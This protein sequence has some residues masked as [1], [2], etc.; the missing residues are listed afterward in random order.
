MINSWTEK[1]RRS[2]AWIMLLVFYAEMAGSAY[3]AKK[4]YVYQARPYFNS[5][6]TLFPAT[7]NEE[8]KAP[9]IIAEKV[10]AD[11]ISTPLKV[12]EVTSEG[13]AV[14]VLATEAKLMADKNAA[15]NN[16]SSGGPGQPESSTFKSVGADNMV[17]LFTGDFSYNI[18]L[19]DVD[20]YPINI[21]Y[22][23]GVTMDQESSWVG[24]GWNI[25]SGS[26]N[27]N[28]RGVPDDFDGSNVV[29][30]EQSIEPEIT[31]GVN[32][33]VDLEIVGTPNKPKPVQTLLP[34]N[35]GFSGGVSYNNKRGLGIEAG[36]NAVFDAQTIVAGKVKDE[37]T[38]K[39][40]IG[41]N[42][43]SQT[44]L[45][46]SLGYQ[47]YL[48]KDNNKT[49]FGLST[50]ADFNA[51]TGLTDLRLS[52]EMKQQNDKSCEYFLPHAL[53]V[54]ST[55]INFARSSY[56]PTIRMPLTNF[57]ASYRAQFGKEIFSKTKTFSIGGAYNRSAIAAN[58][59]T[60]KKP[61]FGYMYYEKANGNRDALMDFNRLN[62]GTYNMK[63]PAISVPVYTY[64]VF[65][66]SGEGTGGS[67]RGYRGN[68]GYVRD[69]YTRTN[70][71]K[72]NL[73][74]EFS[75]Q[76]KVKVGVTVG[77][78]YSGTVVDDWRSQNALRQVAQFKSSEK[79]VQSGFYF[80]NPGEKAIIDQDYYHR[81]G[82]DQLM[83]PVMANVN[84]LT[85]P[86]NSPTLTLQSKFQLYN[87]KREE[88]E[89]IPIDN[90]IRKERDKRGQV[91]SF[92][93][94][95]EADRVGLDRYI[96]SYPELKESTLF[97]PGL[98]AD[99]RTSKIPIRRLNNPVEP[100]RKSNHISEITVQ[101][102]SQR[103]I[104]G[105]PV[106]ETKR[107]EVTF[108]IE[109]DLNPV[110]DHGTVAYNSGVD[111]S[112]DN[113]KGR[114]HLFQAETT[115][116][117][118]HSFLLT[119]ILS[120]DYVD[121]TGN[122]ISDDDKG[123][124]IKFNYSRTNMKRGAF[125]NSFPLFKWRMPADLNR[126][127]YNRGLVT[128]NKDDKASYTYGEK[129][130][131]YQHSI[132]SKNMIAVFRVSGKADGL[133]I[134]GENGFFTENR[135]NPPQQKLDRIDL[136]S[137]AD[138][139]K[140]L[141][142]GTQA[143][144]IK[145]VHFTYSYELCKNFQYRLANQGK[146]TLKSIYFT[147]R[148]N[149]HQK[150]KYIFKY[151]R[152]DDQNVTYNPTNIDRWGVYKPNTDNI[153]NISNEDLP[154]SVQNKTKADLNASTWNLSQIL[155]P[156]GAK[157]DVNY[158][159]D[160]YAY[161]QDK[162]AAQMTRIAG[163][164][165]NRYSTPNNELY[166]NSIHVPDNYSQ[167]KEYVFFDL[168]LPI[169]TDEEVREKYLKDVKQLLLKLWVKVPGDQN[170]GGYEPMFVYCNI[171]ESGLATTKATP[172]S[173][174]EINHNR[175]Y[176][177]IDRVPQS[178][179]NGP[180][181]IM[182][183][184]YQ[185]LRDQLPSKAYPGYDVQGFPVLQLVR[186]LYA[187]VNNIRTGLMGFEYTSRQAGW[188]RKTD[189]TKSGARLANPELKKMGGGHR[190]K[191]V[192]ITDNWMK[193]TKVDET[194][195][196]ITDSWYGQEYDYTTTE[197][198]NGSV[199][200]ISS[201]V[202]SYEPAVGNEENPFREILQYQMKN[203]MGP[204]VAG[205]VELPLAETFFPSPIVGYSK[206]V[207]KS[208]HNKT[209]KVIRSNIGRQETEFYTTRDFPV[210]SDFTAF[211]PASRHHTTPGLIDQIFN[212]AR[213]DNLLLAQGFRV[214]LNDMNGKIKSQASYPDT[215]PLT[216][217][218]KTTYYYRTKQ[219]GDNKFKLD[220][221]IPVINDADGKIYNKLVGKDIE[222]M[223]DFR[224]HF[225]FTHSSQ[226]PINADVFT[227]AGWPVILP[228]VF[229]A[230]FQDESLFRSATTMK[231]V[232]EYGIL[233]SIENVDKGSVTGTRNL[234]YDAETGEALI[235]RTTKEF[236]NLIY[237]FNYPA[238]WAY[239]GMGAAYKNIDATVEHILMRNGKI[240][241]GLTETEIK[242]IFES[243][244]EIY[245]NEASLVGPKDNAGC[246]NIGSGNACTP[247]PLS[248]E[249]R[250]W[251]LDVSKD[252]NNATKEFIFIDRNG[253]PYNT[254]D[255]TLRIIRSG[256]RNMADISAG[257]ITS[258]VNPIIFNGDDYDRVLINNN[259]QVI[260]TG[261]VE[262]KEKWKTQ[263]ALYFVKTVNVTE[264]RL[265]RIKTVSIP[266]L[267]PAGD[268]DE[269]SYEVSSYK[270]SCNCGYDEQYYSNPDYFLGYRQSFGTGK[271]RSRK[272]NRSWINLNL[273]S[274]PTSANISK[275][276]LNFPGHS[277]GSTMP[278][279]FYYYG[280]SYPLTSHG[281]TDPHYRSGGD[282][283][284][285]VL[286]RMLARWPHNDGQWRDQFYYS[287]PSNADR[288]VMP[289]PLN[290]WQPS[291]NNAVNNIDITNMARLMLRDYHDPA[292]RFATAIRLNL[293]A[294]NSNG[295]L[296]VRTCF[297]IGSLGNLDV[298]YTD[299]NDP[300]PIG[301]VPQPGDQLAPCVITTTTKLCYSVFT[302]DFMN[303]YVQG[304]LGNWR[305]M[306]SYA[307]NG[308]RE[309][310]SATEP[311]TNIATAGVIK[312]YENFWQFDNSTNTN[313]VLTKTVPL[314]K[315]WVWTSEST[316]FNRKG[317]E[318]E[319]VDP[320]LRYNAA[321]FGYNEAL[322]VAT[323]NNS[324][325]R[326]A[327]F[328]GFEDYFFKDQ[329]C[330]LD[331]QPNK[332]HFDTKINTLLLDESQAHTG[333]YSLR[334]AAQA[335]TS[336]KMKISADNAG[337]E[338]GLN[339]HLTKT[340]VN[341]PWVVPKGIGLTGI[342]HF[343]G[344]YLG[345]RIDEQINISY[346]RGSTNVP[347][348]M[349]Y[350]GGFDVSWSGKIQ[351]A[352]SGVYQFKSTATNDFMQ[353]V[354][355]KPGVFNTVC[356]EACNDHYT[357]IASV[358]HPHLAPVTLVAGELYDISLHFVDERRRDRG[359]DGAANLSWVSLCTGRPTLVPK[360][361]L[362]PNAAAANGSV[363]A[364]TS[365]CV[366]VDQIKA[367]G[368]FLT[369]EFNLIPEQKMISSVWVK[370]GGKDEDCRCPL[371]TGFSIKL[372]TASNSNVA[373]YQAKGNI[374][375][376]WQLFE[377]EFTVPSDAAELELY[378]DNSASSN[379]TLS[380]DD[381][382][383]HPFSA[384]MKSFVYNP[385][386]LKP[387]AELDE[388][389]YASFYEY[390]DDGTLIRVKKETVQGI[391]TIQESRSG[392]QKSVT[393]L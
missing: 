88:T 115:D 62:D 218:N 148:N 244:D 84:S 94:A 81:M 308:M 166:D 251:A 53:G 367:Q 41:A 250:I 360:E 213:I 276:V 97:T 237:S 311:T 50:S 386:N 252:I 171:V 262:F 58:R 130:L 286:E 287:S 366:K 345:T 190:V 96:Y 17:N 132:E 230:I 146:L 379:T 86:F 195:T 331:C 10:E 70:S 76:E 61:A 89:L 4:Q 303:P 131:W 270:G 337:T 242:E 225:T 266:M 3:A 309:Q 177:K 319:T 274:L 123:T 255:A 355:S 87:D 377:A 165:S 113:K 290:S 301:Y 256:R 35:I 152:Q 385:Y 372:K 249:Y 295:T 351:V 200:T 348:G 7:G 109:T 340:P 138:V 258:L 180:T 281:A 329:S 57:S 170:G 346:T 231:V 156:S 92:L 63:T 122:G 174:E 293:L 211:T 339:I 137:K 39:V 135:Y 95:E 72:A 323:V 20:G 292:K 162:R 179:N 235:T 375:E 183:T 178:G 144:P 214:I 75:K 391:K 234:V 18:P 107:R 357:C 12:K 133:T 224:D 155:L 356:Y 316:Q 37:K 51:R 201:G 215:D 289:S 33:G 26:I 277:Y 384:N 304:I 15:L 23:A 217:I 102:G 100:Y 175:F 80:K 99:N 221:V 126:A 16:L 389:N 151:A 8:A 32:G 261:A 254:A 118:A 159:S 313:K 139:V 187:M 305:P 268:D 285:Y 310:Q 112:F 172:T 359:N 2:I 193:M 324:R 296:E 241:G 147:Y 134:E 236:N 19:L 300:L 352:E 229:R 320:L 282:N 315:S 143:K 222:V 43:N 342:Y 21:F 326:L 335:A 157:I 307:F 45:S 272:T 288:I 278:H 24:L 188:C 120:P 370:R 373:T 98:C 46:G 141:E 158:E 169:A 275:V 111:N 232:N 168:P 265:T 79:L 302:K 318:T 64:D 365:L 220:N 212:L 29:T 240:E 363:L 267:A 40:D 77:G 52:A 343:R 381:L 14:S 257:A 369:D 36:I 27:R 91:I 127:N 197:L 44:G 238:Y 203:P 142:L 358:E 341:I 114:D 184:V 191:S 69:N 145:S 204:T 56:T 140:A 208:I 392:M 154:Y 110:D 382:R 333:R 194:P 344:D 161:V 108:S 85:P 349:T 338:P 291:G 1:R 47:H 5:T 105:L 150:N 176:I 350:R 60:V 153:D 283:N 269:R 361:N 163:F 31:V 11:G 322:P 54:R 227:A 182:Q 119:A 376:G 347:Y 233:D 185:F 82:E 247:L 387:A 264:N 364:P 243:G 248:S 164:G 298:T 312:P 30:K 66:I 259:T 314:S 13:G 245:V 271:K 73:A 388:N 253:V 390:D 129:E 330:D 205:A 65:T 380:I 325:L 383:F 393:D 279:Q 103:Y 378:I 74:L 90:T 136:Y 6:P 371:Y 206:V 189:L 93:T 294:D 59:N 22:N 368:N 374:I 273:G 128:D 260:N 55:S 34:T 67:F 306:R 327:A 332:R 149:N 196:A 48:Y 263:D 246:I 284:D 216:P 239:P 173:P 210:I 71:G 297:D 49:R 223:N 42:V 336:I 124:A 299:C 317:A 167:D 38:G 198:V 186:A 226:I 117:Y 9:F 362:Y 125:A 181:R 209:N 106:Y 78:V 280:H 83:R 328:D 160:D 334:T 101:Q 219:T 104:Y 202:A 354:I 121:M 68:M 116:G 199:K 28:V 321:V 25:N 192:I 228:S 353:I 207:V